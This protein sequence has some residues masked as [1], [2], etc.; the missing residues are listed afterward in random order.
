MH[1]TKILFVYVNPLK[2]PY[3]DLGIASLSAYLRSHG[4]K[5]KLIDLTLNS[6]IKKNA[7]I[8]KR[9]NPNLVAFTSRSGEFPDV[10][11]TATAFRKNH[12][13]IYICGGIHPT[14]VPEEVISQNCFDGICIG[15]GELAILDLVTKMERNEKYHYT[16]N[17][18]FRHNNK[19]IKNP[20]HRLIADLNELPPLDYEI[21]DMDRYLQLRCGQLD[22]VS[23]RGC[24]FNC[25]FC[26]N[27]RLMTT[28]KGL[29]TY[30]RTKSAKIIISELKQIIKKY[31]QAKSLKI[32]DELFILDNKRL[33]ELAKSYRKEVG[34]PFECDV[35]A[36]F[37]SDENMKLLKEMGC[38]KLN[39]GIETGDEHFRFELL[40]KKITDEQIV[41]AFSC[42]KKYGIHTMGLNMI[43]LPFES[44]EQI[45][46]TIKLN[47]KVEPD[48]IQATIF[49]PFRGTDLYNHCNEHN[50][51]LSNNVEVSFYIG[52]YLRNPNISAK[53]LK[54]LQRTFSY[55]CYKDRSKVKA[56]ILLL[57]DT[58][59]PYYIRYAKYI[60]KFLTRMIYYLFWNLKTLKFVS[61]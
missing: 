24:P 27:H 7:E 3:I 47:K 1:K 22:Y 4:Y 28:Y 35:R 15:E 17:F 39:I 58:A 42:A 38:S 56:Y 53:E 26:V 41:N 11:K 8:L 45:F 18:W 21:F 34:V 14:I 46:K 23:G 37:C 51:I 36:D 20:L 25:S 29:G 5:T 30:A 44:K 55:H 32:A 10:V 57:R 12:K 16:K 6:N 19:I 54:K 60:P 43:G 40:N 59:I 49:T 33:L 48:S 31:P 50:L 52:T 13:A 9:Y 61:K 2:I